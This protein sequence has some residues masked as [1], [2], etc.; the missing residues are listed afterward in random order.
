MI[1]THIEEL[2]S[3]SYRITMTVNKVRYRATVDHYPSEREAMLLISEKMASAGVATQNITLL[4]ACHGYIE[5]KSNLLSVT[6]IRGYESVIR[7][8]KADFGNNLICNI[9]KPMLQANINEYALTR[10]PKTVR[11][12][13]R[14]IMAVMSY[15]GCRIDGIVFPQKKKKEPYIPTEGEV[16]AIFEAVRG[17]K[18]EV[19]LLLSG[20][21]LRRSEICA[22]LPSDL[23]DDNVLTVNKAKV[24]DK[25]GVWIIKETKTTEST[26]TIVL[27]DYLADLIRKKGLY[28][29]HPELIY[30]KLVETEKKL[31]I[32]HFALHKMRHFCMS[33]LHNLGYSDK[34][35]QEIGGYKSNSI[36]R[37]VYTHAMELE[38]AKRKMAGDMSGLMDK[39]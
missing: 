23:S 34:Q 1:D 8:I 20:M 13:G 25:N 14:F 29:G 9:T 4:S 31:G 3:G 19:P 36:L 32:P 21:G 17:S 35:I 2:K 12:Y 16:S 22:L 38:K 39:K 26:R 18:Y 15:Y 33:Y 27:P 28:N 37:T 10:S 7:Q 5:T 30:R 24:Q 6:S 11:N